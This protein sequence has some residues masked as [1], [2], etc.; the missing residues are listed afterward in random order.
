VAE[1]RIEVVWPT[2]PRLNP[3]PLQASV[4]VTTATTAITA[5]STTRRAQLRA[6]F[7]APPMSPHLN[8]WPPVWVFTRWSRWAEPAVRPDAIL[9]IAHGDSDAGG[10]A[11]S[12]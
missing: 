12:T 1:R 4:H 10:R 3:K 6:G 11:Y 5:T 9:N 7:F 8:C 2:R